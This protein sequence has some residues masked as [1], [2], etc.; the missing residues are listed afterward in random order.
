MKKMVII[1]AVLFVLNNASAQPCLPEGVTFT[2]QAQVNSFPNIYP[3]C[4]QIEGD[5][6]I[7]GYNINNLLGLS[8]V[9]AIGGSLKIECTQVLPNLT[10]LNNLSYIGGDLHCIE[11]LALTSLTGLDS[12]TYIGR[13]ITISNNVILSS[14]AGLIG[15]TSVN[16]MLWIDDNDVLPNLTGLNNVT[17]IAGILKIYSDESLVS[18]T[19]LESLTS[20][21]GNLVIGGQGHLGGIGNPMLES[22]TALMNVTSVGGTIEIGYN[23]SLPSLSGLD[24][25]AAGSILNLSVYNNDILSECE[26]ASVCNY[27]VSPKGTVNISD[28]YEGCNSVGEVEQACVAASAESTAPHDVFSVYPN[29]SSGSITIGLTATPSQS[30]FEILNLHGQV[31][32]SRE[33]TESTTVIDI[34]SL[35]PGVY[36]F[37]IMGTVTCGTGII[38]RD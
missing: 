9:T 25:I 16:G 5:V 14:L 22:L 37:R 31:L 6:I 38:I 3:N 32:I 29:P 33:L 24:N 28:N 10:G 12:V 18:L 23:S 4:T 13:D 36:F 17:S 21:G 30:R 26:V 11:N 8:A 20:I 19:G 2:T 35:S 7:N 27:L 15:L 1:L 34:S